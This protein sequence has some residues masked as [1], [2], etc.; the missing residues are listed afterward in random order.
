MLFDLAV[1]YFLKRKQ[2]AGRSSRREAENFVED[3]VRNSNEDEL[4]EIINVEQLRQ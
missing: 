4:D 2:L 1:C 3:V